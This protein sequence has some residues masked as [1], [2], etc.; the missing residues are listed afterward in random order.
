MDSIKLKDLKKMHGMRQQDLADK[1]HIS[2]QSIS[3][4]E[5]GQHYPDITDLVRIAD[6]FNVPLW[7]I[8]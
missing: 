7:I 3:R 2:Q 8:L 5:N 4:Y 1:L 6:Y